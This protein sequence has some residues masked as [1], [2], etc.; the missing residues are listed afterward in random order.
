MIRE[1]M[2]RGVVTCVMVLCQAFGKIDMGLSMYSRM[3]ISV[4]RPQG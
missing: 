3:R 4:T 1:R 2:A